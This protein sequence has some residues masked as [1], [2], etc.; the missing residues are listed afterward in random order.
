M[1]IDY[2]KLRLDGVYQ[3]DKDGN[4]MLRIKVPAGVISSTQAEAVCDIAERL[5]NGRLH[6]TTRGSIELHRLKYEQLPEAFRRLAAV[7]L[8]SRGACGGAVRGIACSTTFN[9]G[10]GVCQTIARRL[11]RHFAGNPHF[12]GLPKKFK[13]GID[14]GYA[15]SRHLIQDVGLVHVG[16]ADGHHFFD[17]WC[18]GGLGREPQAG[19]LLE[20][21]VSEENLI[22][23]IEAIVRIYRDNTPPPKRLKF[24]ISQIGKDGFRA[25]LEKQ[26]AGQSQPQPQVTLDGPLT[27]PT[28]GIV[29]VSVFAG[30]LAAA[31]F[32]QLA[33]M[34]RAEAA[35]FLALSADQNVVLLLENGE[36][37]PGIIK[38]I[39]EIEKIGLSGAAPEHQ[40]AFRVCPGSHEC[41]MGLCATRDIAR[42]VLTALDAK[43]LSRSFAVSG[44]PNSCSHPQ[45]ADVGIVTTRCDKNSDGQR[46]PR[47]TLYRRTGDGFGEKTHED[48]NREELLER[49]GN[50]DA[51]TE[52]IDLDG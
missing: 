49:I 43:G 13:I 31:D 32:R 17:V 45:L 26:L 51:F 37:S 30:E 33:A 44:C 42:D 10:F 46:E 5:T 4:L 9:P 1:S 21:S 29:E 35:G 6:L 39:K 50:L 3:Q 18:A 12:E 23:M 40:T 28:S 24:L 11:N 47:F 7:G 19:F 36:N 25:L 14:S 41:K 38:V 48:L 2:Q 52:S 22:P 20:K 16:S 34:A 8:S 27:V 15:G